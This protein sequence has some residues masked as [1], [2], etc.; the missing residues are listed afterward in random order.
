MPEPLRVLWLIKGLGAGGA[1]RLLERAIPYLDRQQFE[2]QVAYLLPWKDALVPSFERASIPVHCLGFRRNFDVM[3]LRRLRQLVERNRIDLIHAHLPVPG[4]LARLARVGSRVKW[5]VYTEHNVPSRYTMMTRFLN[6]VTYPM[7]DAAIA[8]SQAISEE[9]QR[10]RRRGRP[11]L[12]TI[13]NGVELEGLKA[14]NREE[15]CRQFGFPADSHLIVN[16]ANF[17]HKK[18]HRHL[19]AAAKRV[20]AV[21]PRARFLL[22]GSGPLQ[23]EMAREAQRLNLNGQVVLT[24][25]RE[26]AASLIGA[27]DIFVLASV[28][29]GLP[30]SL[31]E[32]MASAR[33]VVAT[34]VGGVP[35]LISDETGVLVNPTDEQTLAAE[36]VSL[37]RN[38]ERRQRL[39]EAGRQRVRQG[40]GIAPMVA[41]VENV[42][43]QLSAGMRTGDEA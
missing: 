15:V 6:A 23:T 24:G 17:V 14:A 16:V 5:V 22:V 18:G 25:F 37:L 40:F 3:V 2:Y 8:V 41:A 19:L 13:L 12:T 33:P 11:R 9:V 1:E 26:D 36:V 20:L 10:Y 29:E 27:A 28:H 35:E 4:F 34:R 30:V 38:P 32:A 43:L 21:E 31:L 7:N 39:G 42:Y